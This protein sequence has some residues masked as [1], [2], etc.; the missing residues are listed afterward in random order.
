[1]IK[2][3][4]TKLGPFMGKL[5]SSE[6]F[7]SFLLTEAKVRTEATW[8]MDGRVN[9]DFFTSEEWEEREKNRFEYITWQSARPYFHELIRGRRAPVSF[10]FILSLK[11]E[12]LS[13]I[14]DK[15]IVSALLINV[16]YEEGAASLITGISY[17]AFTLDRSAES[18]WDQ[19]VRRFLDSKDIVYSQP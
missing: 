15:S 2:L 3:E 11:P 5:L 4:I 7:D 8:T 9:R 6:C 17:S 18:A 13:S 1:M 14:A 16:N 10:R 19:T 12:Y